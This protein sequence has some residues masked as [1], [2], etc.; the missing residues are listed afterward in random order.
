VNRDHEGMAEP[1]LLCFDGSD[2]AAHAIAQASRL[3]GARPAVVLTVW[4]PVS[5]WEPYDP[6]AI[7]SA[8]VAKLGSDALGLDEI[9]ADLA[10]EK[11][12]HGVELARSAG[13]DAEGRLAEGKTWKAICETARELDASAIVLGA[14]G[15]SRIESALLGSVSTS[16]IVH[17]RRP[18]L[19]IPADDV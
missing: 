10:R 3:L 8:A 17:A 4:E 6:G 9:A 16:V 19:V 15:L 11:M 7:L 13:F 14:R 2:G 5:C 1:V 18:V 12:E